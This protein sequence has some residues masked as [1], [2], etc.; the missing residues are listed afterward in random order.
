MSASSST[1]VASPRIVRASS[2]I[3]HTL[4]YIDSFINREIAQRYR[5]EELIGEGA[6]ARVYRAWD[7]VR[8]DRVALKI[9]SEDALDAQT[10]EAARNFQVWEGTSILPLLEVHPEFLEG[11]ITVMPLM[12]KTLADVQPI[13]A[14]EAIHHTRRV[15]TALDFC[16]GR[17]VIHG[18]VKPTNVFLDGRGAA[19]LGD[20]GVADFFGDGQRG[21]T[22]EYAAPELLTDT[23]R[24]RA[25]DVWAAGVMLYELF[26]GQLPFG[27]RADDPEQLVAD[28][29]AAG[30][31]KPPDHIRPYLPLRVRHFFE[32]CF[33]VDPAKRLFSTVDAVRLALPELGIRAEWVSWAKPGYEAYWEGYEVQAG[34]R[35]GVTYAA[36]VRERRGLRKWE[37]E[38]KRAQAGGNLRRWKGVKAFR[39][40]RAEAMHRMALWMRNVTSTG[41]P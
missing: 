26:C 16:H 36:T 37:A 38:I 6:H 10:A 30:D 15:L 34:N 27:S 39:G 17:G 35:T 31:F 18:D 23:P 4:P 29:I 7:A 14:S 40:S 2:A 11:Q 9:Y 33:E 41:S 25:T 19:Y 22:L 28:R 20:F 32:K 13:F 3:S 8:K 21:H 24:S 5:V 1:P 12:D